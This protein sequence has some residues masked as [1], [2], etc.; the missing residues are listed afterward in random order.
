[1]QLL[2]YEGCWVLFNTVGSLRI[3]ENF[4]TL[5]SVYKN[6]ENFFQYYFWL[7]VTGFFKCFFRIMWIM[8]YSFG[9][10]FCLQ[11]RISFRYFLKYEIHFF[12]VY[13]DYGVFFQ[14]YLWTT[15]CTIFFST[16]YNVWR[17]GIIF[18]C[19]FWFICSMRILSS[20]NFKFEGYRHL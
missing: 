8:K 13:E 19:Y 3:V 16:I 1:M 17:F 15:R 20:I 12:L 6:S 2:V 4:P 14:G 10:I 5:L 7:M 18:L 9:T 11:D